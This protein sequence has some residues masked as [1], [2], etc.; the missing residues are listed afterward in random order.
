MVPRHRFVSSQILATAQIILGEG[1]PSG[2]V[3][4]PKSGVFYWD[5]DGEALW[6]SEASGTGGWN[7]IASSAGI[8]PAV[9]DRV[10]KFDVS[11]NGQT[12]FDLSAEPSDIAKAKVK[13][14]GVDI[15]YSTHYTIIESSGVY[16]VVLNPANLGFEMEISNEFGVP[17]RVKVYY[18]T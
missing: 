10:D 14:N 5:R 15:D 18:S 3:Y 6:V 11:T 4:A 16:T 7:F 2:V 9:F 17:D 1:D 8:S 13:I 12:D